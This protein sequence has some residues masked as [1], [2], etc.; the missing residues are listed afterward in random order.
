MVKGVQHKCHNEEGSQSGHCWHHLD[1][2]EEDQTL[3]TSQE[4][5]TAIGITS[6]YD[7]TCLNNHSDQSDD[8][9]VEVPCTVQGFCKEPFEVIKTEIDIAVELEG[10][11]LPALKA[12]IIVIK[13]G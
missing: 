12:D 9:S 13:R 7:N 11:T 4:V 6:K 1:N 10:T 8:Q 5:V 3:F 2:Q